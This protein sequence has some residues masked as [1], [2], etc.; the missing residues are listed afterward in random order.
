MKTSLLD[1]EMTEAIYKRQMSMTCDFQQ[2]GILTC[3][4][5]D[6][7]VQPPFRRRNSK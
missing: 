3:V 7:P 2:C 5:S 6:E 4:D 1:T